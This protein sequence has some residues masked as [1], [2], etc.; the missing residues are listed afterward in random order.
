MRDWLYVEDHARA[1]LLIAKSGRNGETYNI[2]GNCEKSNIE[3][4]RAICA[5]ID[6]F[7]P[8]AAGS[9]ERLITFVNDRPGHDFRYAMQAAKIRQ[10]LGWQPQETFAT[11]LRKTVEWYLGNRRWWEPIRAKVYG[12]ERLGAGV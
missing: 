1:L 9:R 4:V 10:E 11:G 6:E 12:G 2:G 5:L 3:V 7:A 8:D